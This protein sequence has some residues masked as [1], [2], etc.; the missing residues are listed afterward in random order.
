MYSTIE[1]F[2][3][4]MGFSAGHFTLFNQQQR[5]RLHGHNFKVKATY[6]SIV[7]AGGITFDYRIVRNLIK[8]VCERLNERFLLPLCSPYLD[9]TEQESCFEI[10][11][12]QDLFVLPADDVCA[13]Q[14]RNTSTESLSY[15]IMTEV[16]RGLDE[17]GLL[18]MLDG[19]KI[20]VSSGDGQF[21]YVSEAS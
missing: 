2:R 7:D 3:Q 4:D 14:L 19:L 16:K 1:L 9:V 13:L 6:S 15:F 10:R 8:A 5:E 17:Q 18:K 12:G 11:F 21:A 20:G